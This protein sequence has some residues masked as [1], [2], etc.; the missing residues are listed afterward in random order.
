VYS[1]VETVVNR[2]L[3]KNILKFS[4]IEDSFFLYKK[5]DKN[6][7]PTSETISLNYTKESPYSLED[8]KIVSVLDYPHLY[9]WFYKDS[10][11]QR[12]LPEAILFFRSLVEEYKNVIFII[13]GDVDKVLVIKESVLVASFAKRDIRPIDIKLIKDEYFLDEVMSIKEDEYSEFL[14]SSLKHLQYSD[15]LN[16]LDIKIDIKALFNRIVEWSAVPILISSILLLLT[17]G[18]YNFYEKEKNQ[19]LFEQHQKSK[20]TTT[21]IRRDIKRHEDLGE[22]FTSVSEEFKYVDKVMVLSKIM[23]TA[24]EM[25]ITMQYV[26]MYNQNVEFIIFIKDAEGVPRY[27]KKLFDSNLFEDVK[28]ISSQKLRDKSTKA[29][30]NAKLK[31]R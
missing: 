18:G 13:D 19:K 4:K 2:L 23:K 27:I 14:E 29:T 9:L 5:L 31:E 28:N 24:E 25:N 15:L 7:K 1:I 17:I 11:K 8:T 20:L 10:S 3:N 22:L 16:L 6:I 26:R 30:I 12:F 21:E